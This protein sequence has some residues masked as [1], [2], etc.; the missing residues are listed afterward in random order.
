MKY[1][2]AVKIVAGFREC[3]AKLASGQ[4]SVFLSQVEVE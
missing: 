3:P 2:R 1:C 4:S